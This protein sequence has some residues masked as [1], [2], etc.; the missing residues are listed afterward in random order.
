MLI[1]LFETDQSSAGNI[2]NHLRSKGHEVRVFIAASEMLL[3][4]KSC[5]LD[6]LVVAP[7]AVG[8]FELE[9]LTHIRHECQRECPVLLLIN[10]R[11]E[12]SV[13]ELLKSGVSDYCL[14]PIRE[15]ELFARISAYSENT[16][17]TPSLDVTENFGYRFDSSNRSVVFNEKIVNLSEHE[18]NLA[19]FIFQNKE[20]ALSRLQLFQVAC[21]S[22]DGQSLSNSLETLV[23]SL[24]KKLDISITSPVLR[25]KS[26]Y[27][28]GYRLTS[29]I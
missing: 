9:L 27:G 20:R 2:C 26:M 1:G 10:R 22:G 21:K 4:L 25:L 23:S 16:L 28:F 7:L 3:A 11:D 12:H 24:R 6:L 8:K 15:K 17:Q 29:L 5:S 18:F 13:A 19:V 14:K